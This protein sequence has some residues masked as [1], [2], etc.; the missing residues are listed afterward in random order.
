[1]RDRYQALLFLTNVPGCQ[2][3]T[4]RQRLCRTCSSGRHRCQLDD[5]PRVEL[6]SSYTL[7]VLTA[8]HD[9]LSRK[10]YNGSAIFQWDGVGRAVPLCI[11]Q[12][13][14]C[15]RYLAVLIAAGSHAG[16]N[17]SVSRTRRSKN[18]GGSCRSRKNK[19][20]CCVHGSRSSRGRATLHS[21][22]RRA[23]STISQLE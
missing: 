7:S 19:S 21:R 23:R 3:L 1:M 16:R 22:S 8:L 9:R 15:A 2:T 5:V 13:R 17:G 18:R 6:E 10:S 12:F 20:R 14:A 4:T 11:D